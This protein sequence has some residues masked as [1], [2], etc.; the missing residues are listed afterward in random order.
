MCVTHA[1]RLFRRA[2]RS[3]LED[4]TF[5]M[6]AALAFYTVFSI[7]P[8]LV[9]A[10]M[11]AAQVI[12]AEE[13]RAQFLVW[14]ERYFGPAGAGVVFDMI[15]RARGLRPGIAASVVGTVTLLLGACRSTT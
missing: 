9:I 6:G 12:G 5:G 13:A 2:G 14:G 10:T 11:I 4:D 8:V 7:G 3:A 1:L 15:S